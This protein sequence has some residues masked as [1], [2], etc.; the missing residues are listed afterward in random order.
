[1]GADRGAH[2]RSNPFLIYDLVLRPR[3][4]EWVT[5]GS[6]RSSGYLTPQWTLFTTMTCTSAASFAMTDTDFNVAHPGRADS[7]RAPATRASGSPSLQSSGGV[8]GSRRP[9]IT[10]YHRRNASNADFHFITTPRSENLDQR[11]TICLLAARPE[12]PVPPRAMD[13]G[14]FTTANF[15]SPDVPGSKSGCAPG[16]LRHRRPLH[17]DRHIAARLEQPAPNIG[18]YS[19]LQPAILLTRGAHEFFYTFDSTSGWRSTT[20]STPR[21]GAGH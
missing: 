21:S 1:M 2:L 14:N 13:S 19:T 11:R 6:T 10:A 15:V 12:T 18:I 4:V 8:P 9:A 3:L 20:P 17:G 16:G 5:Q 7:S